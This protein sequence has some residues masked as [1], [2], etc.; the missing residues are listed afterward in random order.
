MK[1]TLLITLILFAT[2]V[3]AVPSIR[4]AGV[5]AMHQDAS[6]IIR[7]DE[8]RIAYQDTMHHTYDSSISTNTKHDVTFI[9][10]NDYGTDTTTIYG[11][12]TVHADNELLPYE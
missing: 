2:S 4:V 7:G 10:E 3:F 1:K 8:R 9:V 11:M 12:I 6:M 5:K